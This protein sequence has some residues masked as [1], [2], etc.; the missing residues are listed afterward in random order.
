MDKITVSSLAKLNLSL[1]ITGVLPGGFHSICTVMHTISLCDTIA[2]TPNNSDDITLSSNMLGLPADE[3]NLAVRAA[4]A[5]FKYSGIARRGMHIHIE[6]HIPVA[7]GL[8]GG[9]SNAA[10]ILRALNSAFGEP[11]SPK[12]IA[13]AALELGSDVPFFLKG[14]AAL[15][16]G[17]GE[18]ISPLPPISGASLVLL[19]CGKKPS[20]AG[21]YAEFDKRTPGFSSPDIAIAAAEA[22][23]AGDM[24]ALSCSLDND[25]M[26]AYPDYFKAAD[27]LQKSGAFACGLSGAGPA[28]YGLFSDE[29]VAKAAAADLQ[30]IFCI[31]E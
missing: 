19:S 1:K 17:Q 30:G 13:E 20:T 3:T 11:L 18:L 14:G 24:A 28:V 26:F 7:G 15:C 21:M 23:C 6:K 25:F 22:I 4:R 29:I 5:F 8:G 9:S 12:K 27:S 16:R 2:I 31:F 10:A